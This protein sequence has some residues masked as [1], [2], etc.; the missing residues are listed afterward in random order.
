MDK[1]RQRSELLQ[2]AMKASHELASLNPYLSLERIAEKHPDHP[3][4]K[5]WIKAK[6]A[7]A[8]LGFDDN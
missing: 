6:E 5:A 3:L 2:A 1:R 7:L 4:V 8:E